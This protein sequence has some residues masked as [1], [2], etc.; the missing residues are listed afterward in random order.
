VLHG[1]K[2][3]FTN[4]LYRVAFEFFVFEIGTG[5]WTI[6]DYSWTIASC[7]LSR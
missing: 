1:L 7:Q 2:S 4:D 3:D 5:L 6:H